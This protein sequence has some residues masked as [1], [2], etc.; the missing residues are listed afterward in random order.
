MTR[1]V[2][3][4]ANR[5]PA[6]ILKDA[7]QSRHTSA[8]KQADDAKA[9][10]KK[11]EKKERA[12]EIHQE[13]VRKIAAMEASLRR[14]DHA[15]GTN[16]PRG[17]PEKTKIQGEREP[18]T[19]KPKVNIHQQNNKM[20]TKRLTASMSYPAHTPKVLVLSYPVMI[21]VPVPN[22][23]LAE[24]LI[25]RNHTRK[26]GKRSVVTAIRLMKVFTNRKRRLK[27]GC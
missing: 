25:K 11:A 19:D 15:Y 6:Q 2:R 4:N 18:Y 8:Q 12:S 14:Q 23:K 3:N 26:R 20:K 21:K 13:G 24:S 7:A 10:A 22:K 17:M 5:N 1:P 16:I 27:R 9:A